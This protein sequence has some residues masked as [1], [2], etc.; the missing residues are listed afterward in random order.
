MNTELN[1]QLAELQA[2]RNVLSGGNLVESAQLHLADD[3]L[4]A[5]TDLCEQARAAFTDDIRLA[6]EAAA[7]AMLI[8]ARKYL[9]AFY[10]LTDEKPA[11]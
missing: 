4:K 7:R 11:R 9:N 1:I 2:E 6:A 10:D 8:L 5:T 3:A